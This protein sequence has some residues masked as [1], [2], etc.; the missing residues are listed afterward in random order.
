MHLYGPKLEV[1]MYTKVRPNFV[2]RF[3]L[4]LAN[5]TTWE[6]VNQ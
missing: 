1:W 6:A 5:G 4:W 3:I 2:R